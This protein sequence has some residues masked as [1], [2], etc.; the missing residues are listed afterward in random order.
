MKTDP[1]ATLELVRKCAR[2]LDDKKIGDLRVLDVSAQSS[3]TDYLIIGTGTSEPHLRALRVE[4]EKVLDAAG[5]RILGMDAQ[6]E[7]GWM[8]IDAFEVMI[9]LF[10]EASRAHYRLEKLWKDAVEVDV[11]ALIAEPKPAKKSAAKKKTAV[12]TKTVAK[13]AVK[14]TTAKKAP[15]KKNA[16]G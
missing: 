9:H 12:K 3:I 2:A 13:K 15:A 4:A 11:A 1:A 14:K 16:R 8:V 5:A 6:Q 7:S 10:L